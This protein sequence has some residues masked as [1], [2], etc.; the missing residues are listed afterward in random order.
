MFITYNS[1]TYKLD[2]GKMILCVTYG[3]YSTYHYKILCATE[4]TLLVCSS[5]N[6]LI[7]SRAATYDGFSGQY[8]RI[9]EIIIFCFFVHICVQVHDVEAIFHLHLHLLEIFSVI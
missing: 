9:F 3:T 8:F 5:Y 2:T 4:C 7:I 6:L 1:E